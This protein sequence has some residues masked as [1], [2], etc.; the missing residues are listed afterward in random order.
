MA[1][2]ET[3]GDYEFADTMGR[4]ASSLEQVSESLEKVINKDTITDEQIKDVIKSYPKEDLLDLLNYDQKDFIYRSVWAEHVKEDVH[5]IC[6][7][8]G[9]DEVYTPDM[10]EKIAYRYVFEGDY[11]CNLSYWQNLKN[12][13]VEEK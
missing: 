12:L 6:E 3:R 2:L 9:Y 11:D 4:V 13:F 1:L 8:E 7:D 10:A 5:S